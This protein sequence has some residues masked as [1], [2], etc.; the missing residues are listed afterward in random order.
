MDQYPQEDLACRMAEVN[1]NE[2]LYLVCGAGTRAYEAQLLLR[3][4]GIK[5]TKNIQ[6]GMKMLQSTDPDFSP[7]E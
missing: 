3:K 6:G 2:P 7:Q 1:R 4:H 5:D